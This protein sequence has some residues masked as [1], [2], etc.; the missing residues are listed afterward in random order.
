MQM[1]YELIRSV[2]F[3]SGGLSREQGTHLSLI[4]LVSHVMWD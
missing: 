2:I 4:S 3:Y 1:K